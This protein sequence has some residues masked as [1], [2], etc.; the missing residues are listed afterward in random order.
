V[1]PEDETGYK[2]D[3]CCR[4]QDNVALVA[5]IGP[6]DSVF[7]AIRGDVNPRQ[8][9]RGKLSLPTCGKGQALGVEE[10]DLS[11]NRRHAD[12]ED[13]TNPLEWFFVYKKLKEDSILVGKALAGSRSLRKG[14]RFTAS[15]ALVTR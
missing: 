12:F 2:V 14:K 15:L 1:H 4:L 5:G 11:V 10:V 13:F 3:A 9:K 8:V 6:V 7:L